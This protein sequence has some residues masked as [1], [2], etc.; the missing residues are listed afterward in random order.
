MRS[1]IKKI[2]NDAPYSMESWQKCAQQLSGMVLQTDEKLAFNCLC[3]ACGDKTSLAQ[4]ADTDEA[5][6]S[7]AEAGLFYALRLRTAGV[8]AKD[9]ILPSMTPPR[10]TVLLQKKEMEVTYPFAPEVGAIQAH[11][12]KPLMLLKDICP[13]CMAVNMLSVASPIFPQEERGEWFCP[14]CLARRAWDKEAIRNFLWSWYMAFLTSLEHKPDGTLGDEA[15]LHALAAAQSIFPLASVRFGRLFTRQIGHLIQNTWLYIMYKAAGLLPPSLDIIGINPEMPI[16]NSYMAKKWGEVMELSPIGQQLHGLAWG[17]HHCMDE[18]DNTAPQF[19]MDPALRIPKGRPAFSFSLQEQCRAGNELEKMGIPADA[20]FVCL[21][22]RDNGYGRKH[23]PPETLA[24]TELR[25]GNID[26]YKKTA[27]YLAQKGYYVIR[28][29][30]DMEKKI[31]WDDEHIIDYA[32]R[33]QSDFMDIWLFSNCDLCISTGSGP[34]ILSLLF[35]RPTVYTNFFAPVSEEFLHYDALYLPKVFFHSSGERITMQESMQLGLGKLHSDE[36][37]K[38]G[39]TFRHCT[40][41][42]IVAATRERLSML[43]GTWQTTPQLERK[44]NDVI[45]FSM[46]DSYYPPSRKD[47]IYKEQLSFKNWMRRGRVAQIYLQADMEQ[48]ARNTWLLRNE[49]LQ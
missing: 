4:W 44:M 41:E 10:W 35:N 45:R 40:P 16:S 34:D 12:N 20:K 30:K 26:D 11:G 13:A 8:Q 2:L 43:D 19:Y 7:E 39:I 28:T 49:K 18:L 36:I 37:L 3:V 32:N 5:S 23:A 15:A 27:L 25:N 9:E 33:Y 48:E 17:T 1:E 47:C 21:H 31:D 42:E 6:F 46:R 22:V 14:H 29:G 38:K 24:W